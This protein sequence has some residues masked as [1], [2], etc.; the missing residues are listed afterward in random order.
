MTD[1]VKPKALHTTTK[2]HLTD[3]QFVYLLQFNDSVNN[4]LVCSALFLSIAASGIFSTLS[5]EAR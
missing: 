4:G 2:Q 3:T 1:V 5:R